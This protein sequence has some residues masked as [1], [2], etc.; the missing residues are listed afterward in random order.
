MRT[1][2]TGIAVAVG[3]AA[4]AAAWATGGPAAADRV[5]HRDAR[6][7]VTRSGKP[8]PNIAQGDIVRVLFDHRAHRVVIKLRYRALKRQWIRVEGVELV[9]P[10]ASFQMVHETPWR[11]NWQGHLTFFRNDNE[12]RCRGLGHHV[13]YR[14]NTVRLSVSRSCL[15]RP[16]WVRGSEYTHREM[17]NVSYI[18]NALR[19]WHVEPGLPKTRRLY[20]GRA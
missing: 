13:D 5:D 12:K 18:D 10:K 20:Q 9:T 15:G 7:D 19:R 2:V 14:A 3:V 17:G 1:T 6:G 4:I 16:R 11:G 8:A